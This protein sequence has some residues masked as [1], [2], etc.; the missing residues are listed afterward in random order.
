MKSHRLPRPQPWLRRASSCGCREDEQDAPRRLLH[1]W[2]QPN[3]DDGSKQGRKTQVPFEIVAFVKP[4]AGLRAVLPSVAER[5]VLH[6]RHTRALAFR[7][8][9]TAQTRV[10]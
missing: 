1:R 6:S 4:L 8:L 5:L 7:R 10:T 3:K 2:A 9:K